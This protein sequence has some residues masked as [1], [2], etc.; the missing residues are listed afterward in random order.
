MKKSVGYLIQLKMDKVTKQL[1]CNQ[2]EVF[3]T[4]NPAAPASDAKEFVLTGSQG[5]ADLHNVS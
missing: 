4:K 1:V 5:D 3:F 2:L